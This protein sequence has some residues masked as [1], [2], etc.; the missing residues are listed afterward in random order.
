MVYNHLYAFMVLLLYIWC[1]VNA[2]FCY[3]RLFFFFS[4]CLCILYVFR[5]SGCRTHHSSSW[6]LSVQISLWHSAFVVF[7]LYHRDQI[8]RC[9]PYWCHLFWLSK[10]M[11]W[12][13][14]GDNCCLDSLILVGLGNWEEVQMHSVPTE[15]EAE[16]NAPFTIKLCS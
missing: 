8:V 6:L 14:W 2:L 12:L 1:K 5:W 13:F 15:T 4:F 7:Y 10:D 11:H 9:G 16:H 3:Y